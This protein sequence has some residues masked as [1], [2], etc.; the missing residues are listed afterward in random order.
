[1]VEDDSAI[2]DL[3]DDILRDENDIDHASDGESGCQA[4]IDGDYD[5]IIADNL[6]ART[7]EGGIIDLGLTIATRGLR[8]SLLGITAQRSM[9][10]QA[11][12]QE[13]IRL[14]GSDR[15]AVMDKPFRD[16]GDVADKVGELA[17][18]AMTRGG[19]DTASTETNADAS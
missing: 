13:L 11:R 2:A 14:L 19:G 5:V 4:A 15:V 1:V 3:L 7:K 18:R 17:A 8:A 10:N 6:M 16:V 12:L 9:L